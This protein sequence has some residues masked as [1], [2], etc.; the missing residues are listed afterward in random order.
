MVWV[1]IKIKIFLINYYKNNF[2]KNKLFICKKYNFSL[3]ILKLNFGLS[4]LLSVIIFINVFFNNEKILN[5]F[6][7]LFTLL[8]FHKKLFLNVMF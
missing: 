5:S 2:L 3:F 7:F 6:L 1:K 4:Y 8:I